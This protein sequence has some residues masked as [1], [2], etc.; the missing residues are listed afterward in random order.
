MTS[1]NLMDIVRPEVSRVAY[2][3]W[4]NHSVTARLRQALLEEGLKPIV[5]KSLSEIRKESCEFALGHLAGRQEMFE[6]V[7]GLAL[8]GI[9]PVQA[10]EKYEEEKTGAM[11]GVSN[12]K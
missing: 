3:N 8:E 1:E 4:L 2:I 10:E 7:F 5:P 12:G 6:S 11:K 9:G